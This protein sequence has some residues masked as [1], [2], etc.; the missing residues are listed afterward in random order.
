VRT[1]LSQEEI[2]ILEDYHNCKCECRIISHDDNL[3][4]AEYFAKN[5]DFRCGCKHRV[6]R[7]DY[8]WVT[9]PDFKKPF[10]KSNG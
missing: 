6:E 10:E 2:Q 5:G 1:K 8:Q 3:E 4:A 7:V 9:I